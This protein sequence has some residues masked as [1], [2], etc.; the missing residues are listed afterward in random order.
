MNETD[1]GDEW[2][3]ACEV[4]LLPMQSPLQVDEKNVSGRRRH[5]VNIRGDLCEHK[6]TITND[7]KSSTSYTAMNTHNPH[8]YNWC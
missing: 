4:K 7:L 2:R 5:P 3:A 6:K 8:E 1:E